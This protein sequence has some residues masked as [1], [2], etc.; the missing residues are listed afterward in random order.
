M[1]DA[2]DLK[3]NHKGWQWRTSK[4]THPLQL[5]HLDCLTVKVTEGGK[6]VHVLVITDH[7]MR[8]TEALVTSSQTAK[9]TEEDPWD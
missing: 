4:P 2:S 8:Y 9:C 6:N 1:S 5:V 7:F 3:V